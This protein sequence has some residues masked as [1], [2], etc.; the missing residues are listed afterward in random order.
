MST[1]LGTVQLRED[2]GGRFM[3]MR[4]GFLWDRDFCEVEGFARFKLEKGELRY[5][6]CRDMGGRWSEEDLRV[7]R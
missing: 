6:N 1:H 3:T 4:R 5:A 2:G 7:L